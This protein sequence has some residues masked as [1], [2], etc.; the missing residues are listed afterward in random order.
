MVTI[1]LIRILFFLVCNAEVA[2][3]TTLRELLLLPDP[4]TFHLPLSVSYWSQVQVQGLHRA[5]TRGRER[6]DVCHCVLRVLL[7]AALYSPAWCLSACLAGGGGG[8]PRR[9]RS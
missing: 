8:R 6:C 3:R 1:T 5:D 9:G 7:Q 2:G 4:L